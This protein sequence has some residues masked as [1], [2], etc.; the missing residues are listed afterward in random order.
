MDYNVVVLSGQLSAPIELN[1][2][3]S[4]AQALRFLVTIRTEDPVRRIDVLPVVWWDPPTDIDLDTPLGTRTWV[5][6]VIRRR[7]WAAED[8]RRSRLELVASQ[9]QFDD[10][11]LAP[12]TIEDLLRGETEQ[13]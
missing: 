5:S 9:V 1:K 12:L 7:F 2:Y 10:D 3:P 13:A 11:D 8:G 6:A 4:G